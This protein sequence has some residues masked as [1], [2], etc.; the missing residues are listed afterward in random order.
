MTIINT[1][2]PEP[3]SMTFKKLAATLGIFALTT[4]TAM[5]AD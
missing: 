5:A 1:L 4:M 2:T 3:D